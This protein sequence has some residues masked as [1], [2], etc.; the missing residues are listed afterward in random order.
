MNHMEKALLNIIGHDN[1]YKIQNTN[2][3]IAGAGGLGSNC[4]SN[5]VRC[6]FKNFTLV[7]Y[8]LIEYSNLNRQFFFYEQV[9]KAKVDILKENLLGI[10]PDLN[11]K[12]KQ[13]KIEKHNIHVFFDNCN[14]IVEA[15]DKAE[16]KKLIV[17]TYLESEKFIVAASGIAGWGNSDEI[18][19]NKIRE[20]FFL[21]GDLYSEASD[22]LPPLS[23]RVNIAAAKQADLILDYILS[24]NA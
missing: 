3:G 20:N 10:N 14:I 11:I 18:K 17:E 16:Y 5:L 15:F 4:A 9:G 23:P 13:E 22:L 2:I 7:D 24:A 19:V 12:T 6:G 21:I 8:D 1:F